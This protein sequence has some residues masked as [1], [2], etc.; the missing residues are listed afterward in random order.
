[1]RAFA[2]REGFWV[3]ERREDDFIGD[4]MIQLEAWRS[5]IIVAK[6]NLGMRDPTIVT[7]ENG[8][9]GPRDTTIVYADDVFEASFYA[10]ALTIA[11]A[12]SGNELDDLVR[13]FT[14]ALASENVADVTPIQ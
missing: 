10:P 11:K 7:A 9:P 13:R 1:V 6:Q 3:A 8:L 14:N 5:S 12:L 2:Q 4:G